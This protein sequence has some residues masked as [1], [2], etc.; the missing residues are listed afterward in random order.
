MTAHM[1][2][3]PSLIISLA[4]A[5]QCPCT[6]IHLRRSDKCFDRG[7]LVCGQCECY[8]PYVGELCQRDGELPASPNDDMC[9]MKEGAPVCS[10]RGMCI[11]GEC[12]CDQRAV[13]EQRI[14]GK[15]CEC[16]NYDCPYINNMYKTRP[17]AASCSSLR[18]LVVFNRHVVPQDLRGS[19]QVRV[20]TMRLSRSV[21]GHRM[22]LLLGVRVLH[23]GQPDGVQR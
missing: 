19:R 10:D 14:T 18:S 20:R 8:K 7:S 15:F 12:E 1:I 23:G 3:G 2:I 13:P 6:R 9:R 17:L 22:Q 21:D 16:R 5:G 4:V 11:E